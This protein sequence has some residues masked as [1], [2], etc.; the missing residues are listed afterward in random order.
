MRVGRDARAGF[1][2]G[3]ADQDLLRG[4]VLRVGTCAR[5]ASASEPGRWGRRLTVQRLELLVQRELHSDVRNAEKRRQQ[6]LVEG[7]RPL[8]PPYRLDRIVGVLVP[9]TT[10]L[11]RLR[12]QA[13]TSTSACCA[14]SL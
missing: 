6:A 11:H 2:E 12:L 9:F 1:A 3:R 8:V 13:F 14:A 4:Q 5:L 10:R 7:T